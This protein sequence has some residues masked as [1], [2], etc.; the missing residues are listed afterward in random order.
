MPVGIILA[1]TVLPDNL[2]QEFE[3][4]VELSMDNIDNQVSRIGGISVIAI[5][6]IGIL[7]IIIIMLR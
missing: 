6:I 5:W 3:K 1:L 2:Y 7:S 4:D